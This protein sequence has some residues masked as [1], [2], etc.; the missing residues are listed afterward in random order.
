MGTQQVIW[1]PIRLYVLH[2][3]YSLGRWAYR[4]NSGL[5]HRFDIRRLKWRSYKWRRG[6]AEMHDDCISFGNGVGTQCANGN[7]ISDTRL[8]SLSFVALCFSVVRLLAVG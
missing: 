8:A 3:P 4:K 7:S 2:T 6:R 5:P 1:A